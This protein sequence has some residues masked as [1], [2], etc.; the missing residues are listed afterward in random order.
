VRLRAELKSVGSLRSAAR[1]EQS[2]LS[3]IQ[4]QLAELKGML[5]G[6]AD[7]LFTAEQRQVYEREIAAALEAI[8]RLDQQRA[9]RPTVP[10]STASSLG[11]LA[12]TGDENVEQLATAVEADSDSVSFSRAALA[13]YEKYELDVRQQ[14]AEDSLVIHTEALS[15]IEDADF[16]EE[17]S[18]LVA[19]QVLAEGALLAMSITQDLNAEHVEALLE[20]VEG[21]VE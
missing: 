4:N 6:A 20:G 1:L 17:A 7:R 16:A 18:K 2:E 10:A 14:L 13:A 5:T 3:N 8:E 15:Q 19:S 11:T 21:V 9:E 12:H